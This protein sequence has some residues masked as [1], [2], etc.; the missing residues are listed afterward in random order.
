MIRRNLLVLGAGVGLLALVSGAAVAQEVLKIGASAPKT[1]PLAGGAAMTHWPNV[2][3]WV[4]EINEAG[5]LDIGGTR[6]TIELV[7]YDD[8][9]SAETAIQ[10]I[11]RMA[12]VDSVDFIVTPYSTGINVATAPMI[13]QHGFPHITT[14]AA[15]DGVKEFA[16]RWPNSFWMLGTSTQ[17]ASGAVETLAKLRDAGDIGSRVALVH[18][19]DAFGLELIAAAKP[20]LEAAG[21]EIV[22]EASYPLGTQD[23]APIISGAKAAEP[24]AFIGFS[25]PGDT[26]A[27][28]EQAQIQN[29]EV[30]AFYT[31]VGTAFPPYA[32]R[33]G[34]AAEGVIGIG[35]INVED[36]K[37]ADYIQR[38]T[39]AAGQGP[40]FWASATTYAGL[41]VLGQAIEQAGSKDRAAVV[42]AIKNGTFDTVIG[43]ISFD[44]NVNPNVWTVGQWRDGTFVAV[45]AEGMS[46]SAEPVKKEGWE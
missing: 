7:E 42:E 16:E 46:V 37:V 36:P 35:G 24:D 9:T 10:N 38:H 33:F 6:H 11:Q 34:A 45:A 1:G 17:L 14:S 28:T 19:A 4:N 13:A 3:M 25:Y 43:E 32:A 31:G 8:Q 12:T 21:F 44:N 23:V 29:L 27:L 30:G 40:D 20:A 26:F 18:V 22:Y 15:T 2:H 39:A 41:Q 5:G